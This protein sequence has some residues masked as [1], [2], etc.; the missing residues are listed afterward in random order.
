[1][2]ISEKSSSEVLKLNIGRV[3][4]IGGA[5]A[6]FNIGTSFASG[7]EALQ[8]FSGHGFFGSLGAILISII[9]FSWFG[10]VVIADGYALKLKK[11]TR[12]FRFY[13][14]ERLGAAFE[15]IIST[16]LILVYAVLVSAAG[17]SI[18]EAFGISSEVGK[19]IIVLTTLLT[20]VLGLKRIVQ[21]IG[22]ISP[23]ML[24]SILVISLIAILRNPSEIVKP[25]NFEGNLF[26]NWIVSGIMYAAFSAPGISPYLAGVGSSTAKSHKESLTGGILGAFAII[27]SQLLISTAVLTDFGNVSQLQIPFIAIARNIHPSLARIFS[28]MLLLATYAPAVP[29]LYTIT[30]QITQDEKSNLFRMSALIFAATGFAAGQLKFTTMLRIIFPITGYF[31]LIFLFGIFYTKYILKKKAMPEEQKIQSEKN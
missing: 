9:L 17:S 24:T 30:N 18:H 31:G 19:I 23:F 15:W 28:I 13:L 27:G 4:T 29:M 14:G 1:M 21:I 8:Y 2:E 20:V 26:P 6:G 5:F 25:V 3:L 12:I 22:R 11:T 10:S 7:Q 16:E